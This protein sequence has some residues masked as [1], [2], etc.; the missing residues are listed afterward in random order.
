MDEKI[1]GNIRVS[2]DTGWFGCLF[3]TSDRLIAARTE[4]KRYSPE[5]SGPLTD[6]IARRRDRRVLE[7]GEKR[8]RTYMTTHPNNILM[9][10][11]NNIAISYSDI[12]KIEMKEP[13]RVWAGRI[14][15]TA[16]TR[17]KPYKYMLREG[18]EVFD[19]HVSLVRSLMSDR[20]SIS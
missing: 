14:T 8:E 17:K 6:F 1:V 5:H 20:L 7:E 18:K 11:K 4:E 2:F 16:K 19:Q 15:I 9:A 3:F 12:V 13:G 10:D